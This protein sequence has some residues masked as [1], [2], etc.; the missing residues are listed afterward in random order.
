MRLSSTPTTNYIK[1]S[2]LDK[3]TVMEIMNDWLS[4]SNRSLS[5]KQWDILNN[6]FKSSILYPLYVKLIFDI[7]AKWPSYYVPDLAFYTC[8]NIDNCIKYYLRTLE[9][10]H[11]KILFSRCMF[12]LTMSTNGLSENELEDILSIDDQVLQDV[13]QYHEP[14]IRRFP[15]ALWTRIKHD[16]SEYLTEKEIDETRVV[17]WFHRRFIE[18]AKELYVDCLQDTKQHDELI[19]NVLHYFIGT[20]NDKKKPFFYSD[21]VK[22]KI[23]RHSGEE[24]RYTRSQ[25]IEYHSEANNVLQYNKRKL[26][27]F[28]RFILKL[29][30]KH[31]KMLALKQHVYY[32]Y[33][34]MHAKSVLK[35]LAFLNET[36]D[37]IWTC[38][39]EFEQEWASLN[40]PTTASKLHNPY[41]ALVIIHFVYLKYFLL[42]HDY[43]DAV[44]LVVSEKLLDY[45]NC[46][47][48]F[49]NYIKKCL[50]LSLRHCALVPMYSYL[51][52][53]EN[54]NATTLLYDNEKTEYLVSLANY[55][56][57]FSAS[58]NNLF[59]FDDTNSKLYGNIKIN[60][61]ANQFTF[62]VY[63]KKLPDSP[64]AK[65]KDFYGG[66]LV[67]TTNELH[68][69]NFSDS[70]CYFSKSFTKK[71]DQLFLLSTK[72]CLVS[73]E[74]E[75]YFEIF[76]I[77]TGESI[78]KH[79]FDN[80]IRAVKCS[81]NNQSVFVPNH[82]LTS[83]FIVVVLETNEVLLYEFASVSG[84]LLL[85]SKVPAQ[86]KADYLS[87]AVNESYFNGSCVADLTC[88]KFAILYQNGHLLLFT[89]HSSEQSLSCTYIKIVV[90]VGDENCMALDSIET[91][92]ID[93]NY[94]SIILK[95]GRYAYLFN[96][97]KTEETN[98][99]PMAECFM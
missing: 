89:Y 59:V 3:K 57:M 5:V 14:P 85:K 83:V 95:I 65:V 77:F 78:V 25:E 62:R 41:R 1:I 44:A 10:V 13:F 60:I 51:P 71:I 68:S 93:Y 48:E 6:L 8:T 22:N 16:L 76:D 52:L 72:Y 21:H 94:N 80:R 74:K 31:V 63:L 97:G 46:E 29:K 23:G 33:T 64:N 34:F 79:T 42:I 96:T 18:I 58:S 24:F 35:D 39:N 84:E 82:E 73:E 67:A 81:V 15:L 38:F 98:S 56:H 70:S 32:N 86:I 43:P 55:P 19:M 92:I 87:S 11:G 26:N 9:G 28:P 2:S 20:W 54:A 88:L 12:Y 40:D 30:N 99:C 66:L 90:N 47:K 4:K 69:I 27:E 17:Y 7:V 61:K 49:L 45:L 50:C 37:A 53:D 75:V 91:C 36:G